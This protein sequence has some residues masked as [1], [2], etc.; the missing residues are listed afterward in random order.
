MSE[1]FYAQLDE[2]DICVCVSCLKGEVPEY[3]YSINQNYNPITGE[4]TNED[5]FVSR[6]IQIPVYS[7]NFIGLYYNNGTWEEA[8]QV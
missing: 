2:N 5:V 3:N 4:T 7:T 6:M 8:T 1:Y